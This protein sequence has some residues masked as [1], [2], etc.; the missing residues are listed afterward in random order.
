MF[1]LRSVSR[2]RPGET[3]RPS[4]ARVSIRI[5]GGPS[6]LFFRSPPCLLGVA[7]LGEADRHRPVRACTNHARIAQQLCPVARQQARRSF[8]S[9]HREQQ[10]RLAR[11]SSLIATG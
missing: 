5:P 9:A 1:A 7:V 10:R 4:P 6:V 3:N 11:R 8:V 2:T